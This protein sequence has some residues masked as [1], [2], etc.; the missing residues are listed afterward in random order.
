MNM[1]PH[2]F[3]DIKNRTAIVGVSANHAKWG[4]KIYDKLKSA[5]FNVYPVNPKYRKIDDDT[6]YPD[7]RS[8][9]EKPDVVITA[10]PPNITE[11]IVRECKELNIG[12]IWMQPGSE[13]EKSINFCENN[14]IK[15]VYNA[16]FVV[17]GL[18]EKF[19]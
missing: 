3:L 12:K 15:A 5:G 7:L 10:V 6:C 9:P 17:N 4:W 11:G 1:N 18:K 8:L 14:G 13:S 19:D 2:E 16:C